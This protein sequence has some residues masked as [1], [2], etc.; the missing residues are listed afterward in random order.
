MFERLKD[1]I[2]FVTGASSG[3]GEASCR[4]F[5]AA[6][7]QVI[8]SARRL[9]K[10]EALKKDLGDNCHIHQLDVCSREQVDSLI[11]SLSPEHSKIDILVNNAG[12]AAGAD[13][14]HEADIADWEAMI[15]TNLKGLLYVSRAIIPGMVERNSGHIINLGSVAGREAYSGGSVYCATK[16]GVRAISRALRLDLLDTKVR[17]SNI[18]PG[19]VETEF[20]TVRFKGDQDKA[21]SVYEGTE[22]LV[23]SD[24]AELIVFTASRPEHVNISELLVFSSAQGS[25]QNVH[26]S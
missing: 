21:D 12:L 23:G 9:D 3:I 10:L 19:A 6:G 22:P 13:K 5:V 7:A 11:A 8:A 26:R 25:A 1:K 16:F 15:D 4:N 17:V 14:L 24:I 20:S 2:V 18:E